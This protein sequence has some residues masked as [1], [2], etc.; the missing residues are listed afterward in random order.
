M[1]P[2]RQ[3]DG[4]PSLADL[5]RQ[6]YPELRLIAGRLMRGERPDHTLQPTALVHEAFLR[7]FG[8]DFPVTGD[9]QQVLHAAARQMRIVLVDHARRAGAEKRGGGWQRVSLES[10]DTA[11]DA[12][13]ETLVA[14]ERSLVRLGELDSR[15]LQVV[16]LRFFAGLS[17]E[18]TAAALGLSV[19][20]V[21]R[22]WEFARAWLHRA[23]R[24]GDRDHAGR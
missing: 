21:E 23:L 22:D 3:K 19:S 9:P 14:L 11:L 6:V 12:E 10:G 16:E 20:T 15:S 13:F 4:H 18:E 1:S 17:E 24:S 8:S 5:V 7:L 2:V